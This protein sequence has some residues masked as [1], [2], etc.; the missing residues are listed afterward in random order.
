MPKTMTHIFITALFATMGFA[1][2][3][4]EFIELESYNTAPA[5]GLVFHLHHDYMVEDR[6]QPQLDHWELTPGLSYGITKG[7]MID[8]HTHFAKF[9]A[10]HVVTPYFTSY[11]PLG[12][13]PFLEAVA[14]AL[15]AKLFELGSFQ[16]GATLN[17][18]EPFSRSVELLDGQQVFGAN[19]IINRYLHEH[20]NLLVNLHLEKDGDDVG[21]GWGLGLRSPLT[22]NAHGIAAGLEFLGDFEGSYSILPGVYFPLGM[23]DLVFKTGL[24]FVPG[25]GVMRSNLTLMVQF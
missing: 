10:G 4:M 14:F 8:V 1:H 5:G 24:E 3:A 11:N 17:Y 19:L 18:E 13:S 21:A 23:Q 22:S 15:Q 20:A 6:D 12:P 25:E 16:F 9:G 2:H 7:I